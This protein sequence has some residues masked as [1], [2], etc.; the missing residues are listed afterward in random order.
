MRSS[1]LAR[2]EDGTGVDNGAMRAILEDA[3]CQP[4]GSAVMFARDPERAAA[5]REPGD[6]GT[7]PAGA[8]PLGSHV[9]LLRKVQVRHEV[10]R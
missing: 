2:Y 5:Q 10:S 6:A 3:G 9:S 8:V 1:G 4:I 7:R